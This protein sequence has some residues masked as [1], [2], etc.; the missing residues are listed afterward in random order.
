MKF[1][2]NEVV[3]GITGNDGYFVSNSGKVFSTRPPTGRGKNLDV[4]RELKQKKCSYGRYLCVH[5]FRKIKMVH[6]L[7]AREFIG[8]CPPGYEVSHKDGCSYNNSSGNLQYV[9]HSENELM[10]RLHGTSKGGERHHGV[11]LKKEQVAYIKD[12]LSS[13]TRGVATILAKELGVSESTISQ[14]KSNKRW[15]QEF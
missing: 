5:L 8:E 1:I 3:K 14:I 2:D 12:K 4:M 13:G 15:S 6:R 10:K 7:V 9:T 11:K